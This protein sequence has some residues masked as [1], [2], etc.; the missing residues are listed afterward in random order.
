MIAVYGSSR[1]L[2]VPLRLRYDL[3]LKKNHRVFSS[4]GVSS[5]VLTEETNKYHTMFN[6]TE[7]NMLGNY[8]KNKL[9]LAGAVDVVLGYESAIGTKS[10]IRIEPYL[11]LPIKGIGVGQLQIKT[12]GLRIG[13]TRLK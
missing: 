9:Y 10:H 7:G 8:K 1:V 6:G 3:S 5:F 2:E 11:Q 13:L 12:A 4:A